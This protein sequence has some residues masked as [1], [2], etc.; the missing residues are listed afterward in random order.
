MTSWG[1][2]TMDGVISCRRTR[3]SAGGIDSALEPNAGPHCR[4]RIRPLRDG[5]HEPHGVSDVFRF[6]IW[7]LVVYLASDGDPRSRT[8]DSLCP[9]VGRKA[10]HRHPATPRV[11]QDL[12]L[13]SW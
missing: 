1:G 12:T 9:G 5:F 8:G 7:G 10:C 6:E 4:R 2:E 11:S 13:A 3:G